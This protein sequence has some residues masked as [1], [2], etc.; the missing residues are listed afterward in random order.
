MRAARLE[1]DLN[2]TPRESRDSG[3]SIPLGDLSSWYGE[4]KPRAYVTGIHGPASTSTGIFVSTVL[5]T[6]CGANR[7]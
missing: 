4:A 5:R 7:R 3:R 2:V 1:M 6:N